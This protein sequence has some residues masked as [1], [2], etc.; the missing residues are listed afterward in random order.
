VRIP[1]ADANCLKLPGEPVDE[2]ST[3]SCTRRY[4][5]HW[6]HATQ[7]AS[8]GGG[9]S[10][11]IFGASAVG[12]LAA[13]ELANPTRRIAVVGVFP[14]EAFAQFDQPANGYIKVVLD[15]RH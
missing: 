2:W 12:L 15:P 5:P 11:A 4:L 7:L 3:T 10:V 8:V 9:D 13:A 1:L 6:L 14:P